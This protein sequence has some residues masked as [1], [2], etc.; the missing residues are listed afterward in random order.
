MCMKFLLLISCFLIW[1]NLLFASNWTQQSD[2][3]GTGRH[4]AVTLSIGNKV[5]MGTGHSNGT[6]IETYYSDWWEYDP[7]SS[8]WTQ[9][10]NYTG[11]SGNGE[12]GAHSM[13]VANVGYVGMG[14]LD[15]L[16]LFKYDPLFNLWTEVTGP[17]G[18]INFQ[19]TGSFTI[20][21]KGYFMNL[22]SGQLFMY[23]ADLDDWTPKGFV[24][25]TPYY[26][27]SGFTLNG[28]GY[29]KVYDQLWEYEPSTDT[30]TLNSTFP[31]L[32]KLSSMCFTNNEKAYIVC[33]YN[34]IHSD[35][36]YEVWQFDPITNQWL[37]FSDFPGSSRRYS[38]GVTVGNRSFV[39]TGTN[40]INFNDFWEFNPLAAIDEPTNMDAF[41]VYPNPAIDFINIKSEKYSDF[42][43]D[44]YD[45]SGKKIESIK[46]HDGKGLIQS[47]EIK[48]GSYIY[49]I[50]QSDKQI[51]HGTF[52]IL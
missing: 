38:C 3:G 6:G 44:V 21:H 27:Y 47:N 48:S 2:F 13:E 26:S 16:S 20:D 24:P 52:E 37:Q 30:W 17:P 40:G 39:G 43:V 4:R 11:N 19:D 1:S 7:A 42:K 23:D 9:K 41:I 29:M 28:K 32:A 36:V 51:G 46:A 18:G 33:G 34:S 10:A 31:G 22:Y 49:R 15:K 50:E 25:Y 12:L 35:L 8:T 5:Y 14:E 45:V